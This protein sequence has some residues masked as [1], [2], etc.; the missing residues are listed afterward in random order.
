MVDISDPANPALIAQFVPPTNP[1]VWGVFLTRQFVLAS[2]IN[3]G[4][5]VLR[6]E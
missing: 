5:Y 2:D 1:A 4:L 3:N 6:L